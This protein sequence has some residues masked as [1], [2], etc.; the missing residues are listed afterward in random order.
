MTRTSGILCHPTCMPGPHGIGDL[1]DDLIGFLDFLSNAGQ[2]IWQI[3]PLGPTGYGDSPYQ[4]FSAFAGNPLLISFQ[5]LMRRGLLSPS[6]ATGTPNLRDDRVDYGEVIAFKDRVSRVAWDRFRGPKGK[7]LRGAWHDY[8]QEAA[9]WLDD[10]ALFMALKRHFRWTAWVDWPRPIAL[11]EEGAMAHWRGELGE[12]VDFQRYLQFL[13][14]RQWARIRREATERGIRIMGDMPIFVGHDSADV[15]SHPALFYLD[16]T[17]RPIVVSGVPPDLFSDTGQLWGNPL[18]RWDALADGG[19][20]WW[21]SRLDHVLSQVDLVRIDHFRG[22]CGYWEVPAG[23]DTAEHGRWVRGPGKPFFD[24]VKAHL[25]ALPIVAEDLGLISEDVTALREALGLPG[26]RVLQFGFDGEI[27][28][29]HLP[30]NYDRLCVAYTATHDNDTTQGW[31]DHQDEETQHRARVYAGC[32]GKDIAWATIRL[33]E[34]SVADVAII[35]LQDVL[36]LGSCA[37]LNWP[38]RAAGNWTWRFERGHLSL[39][40]A[41]ALHDLCE[42]CGRCDQADGTR[43]ETKPLRL[44]YG[45]PR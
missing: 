27:A 39:A 26:M 30:H 6:E 24:A 36:A 43:A 22:F 13:F 2:G 45:E 32:E 5:E 8:C 15:W 38:G 28:N 3:L 35:P 17:G 29:P 14:A 41:R 33:V 7:A 23:E 34:Q 18:Y 16:R 44:A 1:G 21:L 40:L 37:R 4:P 25:G 31:Y 12:E 10:Y 20:S 19:Y 11:R 42:A 9:G